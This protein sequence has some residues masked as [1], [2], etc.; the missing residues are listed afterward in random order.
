MVTV[1]QRPSRLAL[2][3]LLWMT[4]AKRAPA[5]AHARDYWGLN[6]RAATANNIV[7][8]ENTIHSLCM[9][10]KFLFSICHAEITKQYVECLL[11]SYPTVI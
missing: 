5:C 6:H 11:S 9:K 2:C 7:T 3:I 4:C 10:R 1:L 8:C